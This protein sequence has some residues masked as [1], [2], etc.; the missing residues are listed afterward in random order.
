MHFSTIF[1]LLGPAEAH[2][3]PGY[4]ADLVDIVAQSSPVAMFILFLLLAMSV[5]TWAIVFIKARQIKKASRQTHA[6]LD[7]FWKSKSLSQIHGRIANFKGAPTAAIFLVGFGELN[8]LSK[9]AGGLD[10]GLIHDGVRIGGLDNLHRSLHRAARE[11]MNR[12][13][14]FLTF[15]ATTGNLAPFIGLFGTV[16]GIINAFQGIGESG[17]A[18]LATVAPGIAEA[19]IA[20][21]AGL[22]AAIPAVAAY[23]HFLSKIKGLE[24]EMSAFSSEFLNLVER[25][26]LRKAQAKR[27][28]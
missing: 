4:S 21:A 2:A 10:D 19:L 22:A 11:E 5:A 27:S 1:S 13:S 8:K 18:S 7:A 26:A 6:F 24:S 16:V 12:L 3:S 28:A 25:D 15:L 14:Q 17:S 20:T 23:N 9:A